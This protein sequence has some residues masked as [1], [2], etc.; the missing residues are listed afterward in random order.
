[1][2]IYLQVF[3]GALLCALLITPSVIR[4]AH[5]FRIVDRPG[6]RK[7]HSKSIPHLGGVAV[8]ASAACPL[9]VMMLSPNTFSGAMRHAPNAFIALA[10]SSFLIFVVG[11][12]DDMRGL[13]ARTKF[14]AQLMIAAS[15]CVWGGRIESIALEGTIAWNL[16]WLSWPLTMLWI[17]GITNAVNLSDGLDGLAAGICFVAGTVVAGLALYNGHIVLGTLQIAVLGALLGFL[18]FKFK[19]AKIFLGDGGSLFLGFFTSASIIIILTK[20]PTFRTFAL[21]LLA[22][23]IPI[24][25]TLFSIL[26]RFLERRSLFSPDRSHLHHRLLERGFKHRDVVILLHTVTVVCTGLG[27]C[28]LLFPEISAVIT[29]G[30]IAALLVLVFRLAGSI[31]LRAAIA[32]FQHRSA[33]VRSR[34]QD[35][36]TFENLQLIFRQVSDSSELWRTTCKAAEEFDFVWLSLKETSKDSDKQI[37]VWRN[38]NYKP[39]AADIIVIMSIPVSFNRLNMSQEFEL[40]ILK[41]GSLEAAAHRASLFGRLIDENMMTGGAHT[42]NVSQ[43]AVSLVD[44]RRQSSAGIKLAEG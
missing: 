24:L 19:P 33:I 8:L 2:I 38:S 37:S 35:L 27:A 23:G 14:V 42:G 28:V 43:R 29:F 36:R 18:F 44:S 21:P 11:F 16:G 17:V 34:K 20:T 7:V 9:L 22:L 6:V 41:N 40:A 12:I 31:R 5:R 10:V 15:F 4:L 3:L 30:C 26:R 32:A 1:M 39:N 25:D 13:R